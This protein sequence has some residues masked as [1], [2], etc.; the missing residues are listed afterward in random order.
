MYKT[1]RKTITIATDEGNHDLTFNPTIPRGWTALANVVSEH[2][3]GIDL[4][5]AMAKEDKQAAAVHWI[6]RQAELA[7]MYIDAIGVAVDKDSFGKCHDILRHVDISALASI[8][9][10]IIGEYT[11]YHKEAIREAK[12]GFEP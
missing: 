2:I 1:H 3:R 8:A 10:A 7:D 4:A 11:R 6:A 12:E 9:S 5:R